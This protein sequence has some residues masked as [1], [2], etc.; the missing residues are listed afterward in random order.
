MVKN[1]GNTRLH[2]P[3]SKYGNTIPRYC[4]NFQT[5]SVA[6]YVIDI[7]NNVN[8]T[9]SKSAASQHCGFFPVFAA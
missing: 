2:Y 7:S 4:Y 1:A 5:Y 9:C 6:T 3:Y 8:T